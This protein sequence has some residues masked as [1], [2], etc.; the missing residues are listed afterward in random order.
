MDKILGMT[1]RAALF[2]VAAC[3][4]VWAFVPEWRQIAG[5]LILGLAAGVMN[6][7]LLKRRVELVGSAA[8]GAGPRRMGLGLGSRLATVL[9][10]SMI[11][12]RYPEKFS[13]PA[14]LAACMVLPFVVLTAAW[15]VHRRQ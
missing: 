11:A 13:L 7:L 14:T 12:Y 3:L 1:M 2:M 10:A 9:L 6:A 15:F 8:A 5:G 4:L